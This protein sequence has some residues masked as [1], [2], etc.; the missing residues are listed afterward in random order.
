MGDLTRDTPSVFYTGSN[1]EVAIEDIYKL[2]IH[3]PINDGDFSNSDNT[4]SIP[5]EACCLLGDKLTTSRFS[6]SK[7]IDSMK[8]PTADMTPISVANIPGAGDVGRAA[9]S[10]TSAIKDNLSGIKDSYGSS[11]VSSLSNGLKAVGPV[12]STLG[13][14]LS[15]VTGINANNAMSMLNTINGINSSFSNGGFGSAFGMIPTSIGNNMAQLGSLTQLN[16]GAGQISQLSSV[17]KAS[18]SLGLNNSFGALM[19]N[20]PTNI[21]GYNNLLTQ[22]SSAVAPSL[23][24]NGDYSSFASMA[25]L[26]PNGQARSVLSGN[27][28]MSTFGSLITGSFKSPEQVT[29][30]NIAPVKNVVPTKDMFANPITSTASSA[31]DS[32]NDVDDEWDEDEFDD[33][34]VDD[35]MC[36]TASSPTMK[37]ELK[38]MNS[39]GFDSTKIPATA[40]FADMYPNVDTSQTG[41]SKDVGSMPDTVVYGQVEPGTIIYPGDS[42]RKW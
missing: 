23:A 18:S 31:L 30:G 22:V 12:L 42:N 26:L 8:I 40:G 37:Q 38:N 11:L 5:D 1:D 4:N 28:S 41:I 27:G 16:D 7:P 13:G 3:T 39:Y 32:L 10:G 6:A 33:E 20:I 15:S 36:C 29:Y 19:P 34:P 35:L 9:L 25:N 2:N 24:K 17:I 21:P 14:T